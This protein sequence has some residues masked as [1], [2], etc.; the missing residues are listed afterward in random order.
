MFSKHSASY[1]LSELQLSIDTDNFW[2]WYTNSGHI[3]LDET[4]FEKIHK[5]FSEIHKIYL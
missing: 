2:P 3:N 4:Y 1:T 5:V